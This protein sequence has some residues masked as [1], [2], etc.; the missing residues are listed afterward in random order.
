[1]TTV[2]PTNRE[3]CLVRDVAIMDVEAE[4]PF[5]LRELL[6]SDGEDFFYFQSSTRKPLDE[7]E[8]TRSALSRHAILV[9]WSLYQIAPPPGL[10]CAP[11]PLPDDCYVK[12]DRMYHFRPED[13]DRS[14]IWPL[15]IQEARYGQ[16]LDTMVENGVIP[17]SDIEL[18]LD[19]GIKHIHGL[20]LIHNDINPNNIMLDA[21]GTLVIID[22]DS[23]RRAGELMLRG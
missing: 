15:M 17:R 13:L 1:M 19:Q 4:S 8:A 16:T 9:L 11:E 7:D 18:S 22:F 12:V 3:R 2:E 10:I 20:G 6:W 23:C 21:D 5:R 14:A